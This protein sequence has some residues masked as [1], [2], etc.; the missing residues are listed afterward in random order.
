MHQVL[1]RCDFFYRND[2]LHHALEKSGR[3]G[4]ETASL[5]N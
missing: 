1:H 3:L 4:T 2:G 5:I